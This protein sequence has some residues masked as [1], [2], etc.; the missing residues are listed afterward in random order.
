[1]S[2]PIIDPTQPA[3][4]NAISAG[5]S[6]IR[7]IWTYLQNF[8]SV[9][10]NMTTGNLNASAVPNGLPTPYGAAG[11]ILRSTGPSSTPS[12][13]VVGNFIPVGL[14]APYGGASVPSGWLECDGSLELIATYPA[15]AAILGT[16]FG[17]DGVT[18]FGLPNLKGRTAVGLGTGDAPDA[19]NWTLGEKE[20]EETHTLTVDEMPAHTHS[21]SANLNNAQANGNVGAAGGILADHSASATGST[22]G[23]TSH[24][25]LQPSLGLRMIIK[26]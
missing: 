3:D 25:N 20:G 16:T 26:S 7:K 24:N 11:T 15:L 1:M 23:G 8:L 19:T 6:E 9:S 22:G 5:A 12:W 14:I 13:D 17:G 21:V 4:S 10:F 2:L 18:N